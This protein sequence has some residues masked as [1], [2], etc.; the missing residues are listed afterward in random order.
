M[1]IKSVYLKQQDFLLAK[2]KANRMPTTI[3]RTKNIAGYCLV[4][5]LKLIIYKRLLFIS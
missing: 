2:L 3:E 1:L 4:L 5:L